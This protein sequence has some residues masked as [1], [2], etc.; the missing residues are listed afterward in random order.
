MSS[1]NG[2]GR[3]HPDEIVIIKDRIM[4]RDSHGSGRSAENIPSR[5][6][7]DDIR[8]VGCIGSFTKS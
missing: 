7:T 2:K 5:E 6:N 8:H 1:R 3:R 4:E